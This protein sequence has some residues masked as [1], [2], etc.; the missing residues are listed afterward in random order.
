MHDE[1]RRWKQTRAPCQCGH[2]DAVGRTWSV[3][4]LYELSASHECESGAHAIDIDTEL[5]DDLDG[6]M[7]CLE[8]GRRTT[9]T[10]V[11]ISI[12][13]YTAIPSRRCKK[14]SGFHPACNAPLPPFAL[15]G[16]LEG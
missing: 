12:V 15:Q 11:V 2:D 7:L 14:D 9:G 1:A 13:I 3:S 5:K 16:S 10:A 4:E 8:V 6:R